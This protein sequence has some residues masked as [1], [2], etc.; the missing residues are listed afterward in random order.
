M[1][2]HS[3]CFRD[4]QLTHICAKRQPKDF[5]WNFLKCSPV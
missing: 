4:A 3:I 2:P 5:V 1:S